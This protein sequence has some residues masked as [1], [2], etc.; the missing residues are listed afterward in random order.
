MQ[1]TNVE[2]YFIKSPGV[3]VCKD[4]KEKQRIQQLQAEYYEKKSLEERINNLN[5]EVLALKALIYQL[6]NKDKDVNT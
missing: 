2:H 6:I 5:D 3:V 1:K 4:E